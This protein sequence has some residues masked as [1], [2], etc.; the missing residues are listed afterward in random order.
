MKWKPVLIYSVYHDI[1][2]HILDYKRNV[3]FSI[4]YLNHSWHIVVSVSGKDDLSDFSVTMQNSLIINNTYIFSSS[5]K[6]VITSRLVVCCVNSY[7]RHRLSAQILALGIK[8]LVYI[9]LCVPLPCISRRGCWL[10]V[11]GCF[12]LDLCCLWPPCP[13]SHMN[14]LSGWG[15]GGGASLSSPV[16][17]SAACHVA[18]PPRCLTTG[19]L[20]VPDYSLSAARGAIVRPSI[21][22]SAALALDAFPESLYSSSFFIA[23]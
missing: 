19:T 2:Q 18:V 23:L 20:P 11:G 10:D 9:P 22:F 7:Y 1:P 4:L 14:V 3:Y 15:G 5:A 16:N 21:P 12:W 8:A 13:H 17:L 6:W